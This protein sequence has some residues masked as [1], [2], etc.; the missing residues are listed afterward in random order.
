[1]SKVAYVFAVVCFL[2]ACGDD[3]PTSTDSSGGSGGTGSNEPDC[4]ENPK[5]HHEIIN[6]CTKS[7]RVKKTPKLELTLPEP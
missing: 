4:F 7:V 2:G 1:M 3:E 6:A 5:T